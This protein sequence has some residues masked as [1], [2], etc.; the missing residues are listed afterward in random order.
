MF[1]CEP[2]ALCQKRFCSLQRKLRMVC[3]LVR[4]GLVSALLLASLPPLSAQETELSSWRIRSDL[5]VLDVIPTGRNGEFLGDLTLEDFEVREDGKVQDLVYCQLVEADSGGEDGS[6]GRTG[7]TPG[8]VEFGKPSGT[9]LV[10][11]LDLETVSASDLHF[12]RNQIRDFLQEHRSAGHHYMLASVGRGLRI[13]LPF[14]DDI[15]RVMEALDSITGASDSRAD[16][17]SLTAFMA[18]IEAYFQI[19]PRDR[20]YVLQPV[21]AAVDAASSFLARLENRV[22]RI[23]AETATLAR[24][25]R[26]LPGRKHLVFYSSGYPM[27]ASREV[28]QII[29][30]RMMIARPDLDSGEQS[31]MGMILGRLREPSILNRLRDLVDEANRSQVSIYSV[32]TRGLVPTAGVPPAHRGRSGMQ[33]RTLYQNFAAHDVAAPQD[34]LVS[35]AKESGGVPFL[36][37]NDLTRGIVRAVEDSTRY[38][39]LAY[40]PTSPR[41]EGR[42]HRLRVKVS[43]PGVELQFRR[44]YLEVDGLKVAQ[45]EVLNALRFPTLFQSFEFRVD[46]EQEGSVSRISTHVPTRVLDFSLGSEPGTFRCP[47]ETYG[48]LVEPDTGRWLTP[49]PQFAKQHRIEG[50]RELIDKIQGVDY[51]TSV[52]EVEAPP[53]DYQLVVVVRQSLAGQLSAMVRNVSLEEVGPLRQTLLRTGERPR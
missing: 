9:R 48:V 46:V 10:F 4:T 15:E 23:T 21:E 12:A 51:V 26:S 34:F 39:L 11:L 16:E 44:G 43:R 31:E 5:I 1:D 49:G 13:L 29:R 41:R 50:N 35:L 47:V 38:Y 42:Y 53:G 52:S 20:L 33:H 40:R 8:A 22:A 3:L 30:E 28:G 27:T 32:D 19:A 2:G 37:N 45:E 24:Y 17:S 18:E 36:N 6:A 14:T 7:T 25:L